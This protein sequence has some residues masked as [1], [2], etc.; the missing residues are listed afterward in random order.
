MKKQT[1]F[2]MLSS[3]LVC[4]LL[5][6]GCSSNK[7]ATST[8]IQEIL[9]KANAITSVKYD[10]FTTIVQGNQTINR[11]STIWEKPPFMKINASMGSVYQVFIKRP[12]GLYMEIPNSTKFIKINGS[13]PETSLMNQSNT[14]LTN[15]TF[16]IVGNETIEGVATTILQ[17]SPSQNGGSTTTKVW[18]WKDKG[19]PIKIQITVLIGGKTFV[20]TTVMKNFDF[21]D[22]PESEFS[23]EKPK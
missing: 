21:S 23:I 3:T 10:S 16:H 18:I 5:I 14:L 1:M 22:I 19:I 11:T 2:L 12:D 6:S 8:S 9:A 13:S 20:T 7:P 17:Y 4:I 15:I